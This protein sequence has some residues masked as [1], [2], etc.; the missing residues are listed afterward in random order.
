MLKL[1]LKPIPALLAT[2]SLAACVTTTPTGPRP[3]IARQFSLA[4][5]SSLT[6]TSDGR[7]VLLR[8]PADYPLTDAET[9]SYVEDTTNCQIGRLLSS[10]YDGYDTL[11][12]YALNCG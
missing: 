12:R 4:D 10:S 1:M 11:R 3:D 5:G 9:A 6:I 7:D 2:L 8:Y